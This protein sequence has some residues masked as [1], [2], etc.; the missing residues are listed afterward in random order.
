[1]EARV[2]RRVACGDQTTR[3]LTSPVF[4]LSPLATNLQR[5]QGT[6]YLDWLASEKVWLLL[7][8]ECFFTSAALGLTRPEPCAFP[9]QFPANLVRARA[10]ERVPMGLPTRCIDWQGDPRSSLFPA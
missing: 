8:F 10:R 2:V 6:L 1:M 7:Y 9:R 4:L 5:L 3:L